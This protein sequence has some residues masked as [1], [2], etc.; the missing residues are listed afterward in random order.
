VKNKNKYQNTTMTS[1]NQVHKNMTAYQLYCHTNK[2]LLKSK[3]PE[4]T[5]RQIS[6]LMNTN[7][8]S[9]PETSPEKQYDHR[10]LNVECRRCYVVNADT[11]KNCKYCGWHLGR[12]VP[13]QRPVLLEDQQL[14]IALELSQMEANINEERARQSH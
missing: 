14:V 8:R 9:L 4:M 3:H 2:P 5:A 6:A 10:Y 12:S 1:I 11:V 7:W 13:K